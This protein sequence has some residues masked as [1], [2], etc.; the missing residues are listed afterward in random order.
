L[1]AVYFIADD[2]RV[3]SANS[4]SIGVLRARFELISAHLPFPF[5]RLVRGVGISFAVFD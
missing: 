1:V 3:L 2:T 5:R 4:E